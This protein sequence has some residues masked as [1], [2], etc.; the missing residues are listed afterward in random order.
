MWSQRHLTALLR[1]RRLLGGLLLMASL[2]SAAPGP[3]GPAP[4]RQVSVARIDGVINPVAAQYFSE[5]LQKARENGSAFLVV[6]LDTPGGLDTSMRVIVKEMLNSPLPVVVYVHPSGARAASAGVMITL[7]A[8]VAAMSPGTNIGAAHP[9]ALGGGQ[10]TKEMS[11]KVEND[12]AAYVK[13]IAEKRGR[14]VQWA[15]RAVR[16]SISA[17]EAEALRQKIVDIVAPDIRSLL[18]QMD[19]RVV[20]TVSGK[21]TLQTRGARV[22]ELEMDL[23][24]RI[25]N[26]I[27]DPNVAYILMLLGVY[28]L[29]F[30]LSN[31]GAILPGVLGAISL[32]LAFFAFQTLPIN[33]AGLLLILLAIG[34]FIAEVKVHSLGLLTA[35]GIVSMILGSLMLFDSSAPYLRV[36]WAVII[37][38]T[39]VT[40]AFFL[41]A[42]SLVIKARLRRPT[43]GTEGLIGEVGVARTP[44][45]PEGRVFLHGELWTA[46]SDVPVE[47]GEP[48][49]V[50]GVE[51]LKVRVTRSG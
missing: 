31:P 3:A 6:M 4:A 10:M 51:G 12:A 28:G 15:E 8:H 50:V 41:L 17:T 5:S 25:L 36:S 48:V 9:V 16:K 2:S 40:A 37:P 42:F 24:H 32:I 23:R 26:V 27:G 33:Y 14:N 38:V 11:E 7:A 22:V 18:E 45:T 21:V 49:K 34:L 30:E 35:G 44:L 43:T 20:E 13:S 1:R 29:I 47:A 39:A 46:V 19:G